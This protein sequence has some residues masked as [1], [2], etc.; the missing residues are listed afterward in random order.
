MLGEAT[1]AV[2]THGRGISSTFG[3]TAFSRGIS[4]HV[5][6]CESL[7]LAHPLPQSLALD[8]LSVKTTDF[9]CTR[10]LETTEL[11]PSWAR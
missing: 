6:T 8:P 11:V 9:A 5:L 10:R 4:A 2:L 1:D 3:L 7:S